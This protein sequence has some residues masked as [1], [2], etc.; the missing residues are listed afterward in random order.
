[1]V[2]AAV[3]WHAAYALY[4]RRG[5]HSCSTQV[6]IGVCIRVAL[7][8]AE[9]REVSGSPSPSVRASLSPPPRRFLSED[10]V[11]QYRGMWGVRKG[12]AL[13]LGCQVRGEEPACPTCCHAATLAGNSHPGLWPQGQAC[14]RPA[15]RGK[16]QSRF[17][18]S[19]GGMSFPLA[20]GS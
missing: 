5:R 20:R 2:T 1:M 15:K 6:R 14:G 16:G 7:S 12:M 8:P 18:G 3:C 11:P 10:K 17:Q 4:N 9:W 13:G 19:G